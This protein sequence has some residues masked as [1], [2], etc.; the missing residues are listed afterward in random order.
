MRPSTEVAPCQ[1]CWQK[2]S[3]AAVNDGIMFSRLKTQRRSRGSPLWTAL[4]QSPSSAGAVIAIKPSSGTRAGWACLLT[5]IKT[6]VCMS[7]RHERCLLTQVMCSGFY[8]WSGSRHGSEQH[9]NI[10]EGS[11]MIVGWTNGKW[12]T[13]GALTL[14]GNKCAIY[15]AMEGRISFSCQWHHT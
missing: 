13:V 10:M 11:P 15:R 9:L 3:G 1:Q 4:L 6:H 8:C 7:R 12:Y 14:L 2:L 5:V